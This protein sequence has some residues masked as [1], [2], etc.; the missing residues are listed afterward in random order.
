MTIFIICLCVVPISLSAFY[1]ESQIEQQQKKQKNSAIT[2]S[3]D[4]TS[5]I[6]STTTASQ[7]E[8]KVS[9]TKQVAEMHQQ[10]HQVNS[11]YSEEVTEWQ[12]L[13]KKEKTNS[14]VYHDHKLSTVSIFLI[15]YSCFNY[16]IN[17][18]QH[19]VSKLITR[20]NSMN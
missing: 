1:E 12:K 7:K 9:V 20:S 3:E 2:A 19:T 15:W 14:S 8:K 17:M 10:S 16:T 5:L 13:A 4:A 6:S 18:I 11:K